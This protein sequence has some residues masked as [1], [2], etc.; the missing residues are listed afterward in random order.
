VTYPA[1]RVDAMLCEAIISSSSEPHQPT[2]QLPSRLAYL[3]F[4]HA[5]VPDDLPEMREI[6]LSQ[7]PDQ[8]NASTKSHRS[9]HH[10]HEVYS[11]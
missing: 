1:N 4:H 9:Q 11:R 5:K 6:F 2:P 3:S 10:D 7:L 8:K